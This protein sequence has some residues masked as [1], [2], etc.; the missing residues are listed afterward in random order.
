[1]KKLVLIFSLILF[2]FGAMAQKNTVIS[3]TPDTLNGAETVYFETETF[4]YSWDYLTIQAA[5]DNIGGT[6]AG[7]LS[8]EASV[9][10]TD[11]VPFT[12]GLNDSAFVGL[13]PGI[14][15]GYATTGITDSLTITDNA[16]ITWIIKDAPFYNYRIKGVGEAS[17]STLITAKYIYK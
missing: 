16:N 4:N 5:C 2:A 15:Y 7:T 14:L 8:L 13:A 12:Q 10:G 3:I 1:M 17:D 6:S 11:W 9:D